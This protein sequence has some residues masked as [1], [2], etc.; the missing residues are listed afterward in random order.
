MG[1]DS[2]TLKQGRGRPSKYKEE[3]PN[4]LLEYFAE[5]LRNP[6]SQQ[7]VEKTVKFYPDGKV[8]ET[9]EKYKQVSR[10]VPTL[11]GFAFKNSISYRVLHKWS[12]E[13]DPAFDKPEK[14]EQDKRPYRYPD[15]VHAYKMAAEFQ[16]EFLIE[17]GMSGSAPAA[18][19]IFAAKNMIGWR[20]AM[21]QR[22]VDANGKD[23]PVP[24][25]VLLP[26]RKTEA[27]AET[28]FEEQEKD[29]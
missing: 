27:E 23:R 19:A 18:F 1:M 28:D 12:T 17:A 2:Q 22:L 9:F 3:Y 7:T 16:K 14:G 6:S 25:Y 5:Y 21:D 20:D 13:R 26:T 8:K 24:G 4:E 10:G 11:F 15:F 29:A